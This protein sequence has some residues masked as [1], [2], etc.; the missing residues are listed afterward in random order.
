MTGLTKKVQETLH[1]LQAAGIGPVD[2]GLILGSGLGELAEEIENQC[3][4]LMK[5]FPTSQYPL[6]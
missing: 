5:R 2:F 3:E 1:Y 4:Y 6:W